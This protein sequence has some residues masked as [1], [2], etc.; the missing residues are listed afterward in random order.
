MEDANRII[1]KQHDF[2]DIFGNNEETIR[3][4]SKI[5]HRHI[6]NGIYAKESRE[7]HCVIGRKNNVQLYTQYGNDTEEESK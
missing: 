1:T 7:Q 2:A 6:I 3:R 4:P 5:C